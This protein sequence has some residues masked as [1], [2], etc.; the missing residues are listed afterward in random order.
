MNSIKE[1]SAENIFDNPKEIFGDTLVYLGKKNSN[2]VYISCDTSL[3]T[4]AKPFQEAFP[5]RHIEFGIQEQNAITQAAGLAFAGKIPII[6]AH[7]PFI[8]LKGIE[9][10]RDDLCKTSANVTIVG[11][12]FGLFHST[13][14]PTHTVLEDIGILRTFPNITIIAPSDGPEY[15]E[16]L[17]AAT[18]IDGP[19]YLRLSRHPAK[20][21]NH[22]AY[23]FKVGKA[24]RLRVGNNLTII[25]TSTMLKAPRSAIIALPP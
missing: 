19:V 20:R 5:D 14:G 8:V 16:A 24:V 9:Q 21:I 13:C 23:E 6:G 25:A 3:G 18:E 4:G 15:R 17:I 10:I 7:T 2:I 11:R 1:K 12:D 22:G